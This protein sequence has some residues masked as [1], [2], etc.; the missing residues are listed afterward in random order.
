[1]TNT[2]NQQVIALIKNILRGKVAT[3]GQIAAMVGNPRGARQVVR[4]LHS[5]SLKEKLPWHRVVNAKGQISLK[6]GSGYEQQKAIL[7]NEGISFDERGT[8]DL[9][10]FRWDGRA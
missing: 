10:R 2:F 9:N 8:I 1:M 3:Y 4:T 5:S 6:P 7:E